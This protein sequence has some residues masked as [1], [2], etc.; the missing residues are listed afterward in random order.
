MGK[1]KD[2]LFG[3]S[4]FSKST[5]KKF[6]EEFKGIT[7]SIVVGQVL[8]GIIQGLAIGIG[9]FFLGVPN[10]LMLTLAAAIVS[11]VPVLGSWLVWLP[12]S[13]I[14]LMTGSTFAGVFLFFY[15]ALF[16]S[17]IDNFLRPYFLSKGSHLSVPLGVIGTIGGL[18]FFGIA[19][20]ILGPLILAYALIILEFYR[21]GKLNELFEH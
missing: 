21:Q 13:I 14:L 6:L 3:L 7:K 15:G 20:L 5:E 17:I 11:I 16:V 2:Y 18:F 19:G 1:L 12:V 9:L 10:A 4:P 8:I